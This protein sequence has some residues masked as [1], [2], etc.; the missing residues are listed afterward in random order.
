MKVQKEDGNYVVC[1]LYERGDG[2]GDS[3]PTGPTKGDGGN[4]GP[5]PNPIP[6]TGPSS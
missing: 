1:G 6:K 2:G 4:N 3:G 5:I